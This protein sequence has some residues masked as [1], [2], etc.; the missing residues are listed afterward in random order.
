[1]WGQP[2]IDSQTLASAIEQDLE[3]NDRA[4]F[5]DAAPGARFRGGDFDRF[6]VAGD[7]QSG[8]RPAR[9]GRR[10]REILHEDLGQP[11]FSTIRRRLVESIDSTQLKQILELLGRGST[12]RWRST[13]PARSR[14]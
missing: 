11:G 7:S 1:M 13:S 8:C 3:R 4:G 6:G 10:I 14:P 12:G 2:Y 5:P 9:S